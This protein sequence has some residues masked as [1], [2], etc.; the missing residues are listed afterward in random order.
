LKAL[1]PESSHAVWGVIGT[2]KK[3]GPNKDIVVCLSGSGDKDV[4]SV[5]DELPNIEL[6]SA[7]LIPL[8]RSSSGA[9]AHFG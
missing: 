9:K 4:Q 3:L 1:Y 5:A 8:N 6:R 7:V 2:A